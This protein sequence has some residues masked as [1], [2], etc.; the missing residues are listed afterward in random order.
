MA[1]AFSLFN[2]SATDHHQPSSS[3]IAP[4]IARRSL[5]LPIIQIYLL[6]LACSVLL[7]VLCTLPT[8]QSKSASFIASFLLLVLSLLAGTGC[9]FRE[10]S[11]AWYMILFYYF[12]M[13]L[14]NLTIIYNKYFTTTGRRCRR[15]M[16]WWWTDLQLEVQPSA[17]RETHISQHAL[18]PSSIVKLPNSSHTK[19]DPFPANLQ[20]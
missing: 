6:L 10:R 2:E 15:V 7:L 20:L 14:Y 9:F 19:G 18:R 11:I 17:A 16:T 1:A 12:I 3:A 13:L 4:P 5:A 8:K